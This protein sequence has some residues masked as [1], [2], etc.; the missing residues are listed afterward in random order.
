[1]PRARRIAVLAPEHSS[2]AQIQLPELRP[3][4]AEPGIELSVIRSQQ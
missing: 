3:A 4:A 1:M 2:S